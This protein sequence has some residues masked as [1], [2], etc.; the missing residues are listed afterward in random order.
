MTMYTS[1]MTTSQETRAKSITLADMGDWCGAAEIAVL[2][3]VSRQRV[4]QIVT[5]KDF[6][7][8]DIELAMG[9]IW[10]TA[11][12]REWAEARGR[13]INE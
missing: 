9:K 11:K 7:A 1:H 6:P 12:V 10:A 5:R 2:L 13:E 3:G 4:Q 8:P